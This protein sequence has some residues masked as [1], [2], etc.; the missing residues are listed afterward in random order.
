MS[1]PPLHLTPDRGAPLDYSEER[2]A[3]FTDPAGLHYLGSWVA[4]RTVGSFHEAAEASG[5]ALPGTYQVW[6]FIRLASKQYRAYEK[7]RQELASAQSPDLVVVSRMIDL[8]HA[9]HAGA[10]KFRVIWLDCSSDPPREAR[11]DT[12]TPQQ[13][14][15]HGYHKPTAAGPTAGCRSMIPV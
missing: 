12:L 7:L 3:F 4:A 14:L 8:V 9:A 13:M 10:R 1:P 2:S 11:E 5:G 6:A 15:L